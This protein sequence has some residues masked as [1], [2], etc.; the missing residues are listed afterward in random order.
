MTNLIMVMKKVLSMEG[1]KRISRFVFVI[2]VSIILIIGVIQTSTSL[3]TQQASATNIQSHIIGDYG[4]FRKDTLANPLFINGKV[5]FI[6]ISGEF[7]PY[8]AM[9]S[10][11]VG[12]ALSEY[13]N[14]SD[15]SYYVSSEDNIPTYN[16]TNAA[17]TS[18]K[19]DFHLVEVYD[20]N[21]Q[22]FQTLN[23]LQQGLYVK[24]GS[25]SIPFICIAGSIFQ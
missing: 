17:F 22:S 24:Y 18:S 16:F 3:N 14:F 2:I 10:W 1:S 4:G 20:Q 19:I 11:A 5:S 25:G 9:E 13:G 23:D 8:C 7:C 15:L 21:K 6:F 12:L